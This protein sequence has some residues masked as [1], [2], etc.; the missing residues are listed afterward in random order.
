HG[1]RE[2]AHAGERVGG[3]DGHGLEL[4]V[5]E[6]E[7]EGAQLLGEDGP[8][9]HRVVGDEPDGMPGLAERGNGLGGAR[10]GPAGDLEDSVHVEE[11]GPH[12][13]RVYA[14]P[15]AVPPA[16]S[17]HGPAMARGRLAWLVSVPLI[18]ASGDTAPAF[19][20]RLLLPG[21]SDH[22]QGR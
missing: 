10:N 21:G 6:L 4:R 13:G 2:D 5:V 12:R 3:R 1:Q 7:A 15:I 19:G 11:H 9:A 14:R 16:V 17:Y 18:S 20:H 22:P 8:R